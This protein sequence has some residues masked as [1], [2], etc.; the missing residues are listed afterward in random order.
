MSD[1]ILKQK[2]LERLLARNEAKKKQKEGWL[3]IT[4]I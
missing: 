2:S 1:P 4:I 3:E